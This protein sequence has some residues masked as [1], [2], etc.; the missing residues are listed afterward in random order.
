MRALR[1]TPALLRFNLRRDRIKLPAW[2]LGIAVMTMYF[3]NALKLAYPT[4]QDIANVASF[5]NSPA[6]IM[7]SGP[8]YGMDN[9]TLEAFLANQY[10]LYLMVASALMNILLIV[11]HTRLEE[12]GGRTEL[13]L[14]GVVGRFAPLTAA[15]LT[16]LVANTALVVAG[17]L[18]L[19]GTGF[20]AAGSLLL[21]TGFAALGLVFAAITAVMCQVTEHARAATGLAAAVLGA[22]FLVRGIGDLTAKHGSALSW[23]SPIAWS[24]Q[25]RVFVDPRWWPLT[26]SIVFAGAAL[27][28]AYVLVGRRDVGA[29]LMAPR[30]GAA[31]ASEALSH[32]FT[33]ALRLQRGAIIGWA[34]G[35]SVAGLFYGAFT[36]SIADAFADLPDDILVIMGGA[37]DNLV[38]GYLGLM[39]FTMAFLVSCFAILSVRRL[40]SEEQAGR[41]DPVLATKTSRIGWMG[42]GVAAAAASSIVLLGLSGVA[43]GVGAAL[44]TGDLGYVVTLKLAYLAHTPAVLVVAAVAALLFGVVPRAFNVVRV[45]PVFGYLVGTF[46]PLLQLP[47]WIGD[48][49]P[50]GHIPQMPLESFA[51]APFVVLLLVA[52]VAAGGG[53]TAFRRRDIAAT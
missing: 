22:A 52:G 43:T 25:T 28:G 11:R 17:T 19:A 27:V 53:V 3:G 18:A 26:L 13:V 50:L 46:G 42:S 16:A 23:L 33:M 20:D 9:P 48:L 8:G 37:E 47:D 36:E 45:L 7:M 12:E 44:V 39:G 15:M 14:A 4:D 6:A 49:S 34:V 1:A 41:A 31:E 51:A 29:G 2:V 5:A 21:L 38:D 30:L 24:Q 10:A 40:R 35:L 32:P